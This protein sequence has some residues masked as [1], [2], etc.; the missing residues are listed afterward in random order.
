MLDGC[1]QLVP[2]EDLVCPPSVRDKTLTLEEEA[3]QRACGCAWIQKAS[4]LM[5]V[6]AETL[7]SGQTI[8]HRFYYRR[9]MSEF[10]LL[11]G[12]RFCFLLFCF[13]RPG[14]LFVV[15]NLDNFLL[16]FLN[17]CHF[18]VRPLAYHCILFP[19]FQLDAKNRQN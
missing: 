10:D 11:V 17:S 4:I 15:H 9:S 16:P 2:S 13:C 1:V 7:A 6:P 12:L 18:S 8:F 14:S 5:R 19:I 3:G